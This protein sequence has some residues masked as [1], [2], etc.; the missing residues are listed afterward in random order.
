MNWIQY[1]TETS[2]SIDCVKKD[3]KRTAHQ[4]KNM[5]VDLLPNTLRLSGVEV[6][7]LA[8]DQ[9]RSGIDLVVAERNM[10]RSSNLHHVDG[11][12]LGASLLIEGLALAHTVRVV[13][14]AKRRVLCVSRRRAVRSRLCSCRRELDGRCAG[15]MEG[16]KA[17]EELRA[18]PVHRR[19]S[20][21][22]ICHSRGVGNGRPRL[23]EL[24]SGDALWA[25]RPCKSL[26]G[27]GPGVL[28]L[29]PSCRCYLGQKAL[30]RRV[31][32]AAI[33]TADRAAAQQKCEVSRTVPELYL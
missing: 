20:G 26:G 23:H 32:V 21:K 7:S 30:K 9:L 10:G 12:G 19:R 8:R 31:R 11:A 1:N 4:G 33:F 22:Y 2:F 6:E 27:G 14:L 13:V 5:P 18:D 17:L 28:V 25:I 29:I 16:G 3:R 15:R 24:S